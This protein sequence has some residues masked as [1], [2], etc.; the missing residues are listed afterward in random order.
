MST[1]IEIRDEL[2]DVIDGITGWRATAFWA[3]GVN[4]PVVKVSR[5]AFDPRFV[6]S[7]AKQ[8][9]TFQAVAY[10]ARGNDE[11][12]ERTLEALCELTGAGS[13]TATVQTS[14]NWSVS[15][16]YAQVIQIGQ[17]VATADGNDGVA[18]L[19]VTFDIEIVW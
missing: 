6:F 3:G 18:Y 10:V 17:V 4:P 1:I 15:I 13:L 19:T 5:P 2:A 16:D 9:A 12:G 11:S 7:A 14:S 8:V